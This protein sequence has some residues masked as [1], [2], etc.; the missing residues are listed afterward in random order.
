VILLVDTHLLLWA[1]SGSRK[2]SMKARRVL[3]APDTELWFS[4][5]SLWEIV[6]KHG[7]GREDFHVEPRRLRR[8]LLDN[9]WRELGISSEHAVA[10]LDLPAIHK[11]PF[12]RMLLAQA[13]VEGIALVTSDEIVAQYPGLVRK[14]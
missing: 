12:D 3:Q 10:T 11:D 8:A 4:A 13:H 2:L 6:I 1:A 5:A 9:G 7:L 14:L